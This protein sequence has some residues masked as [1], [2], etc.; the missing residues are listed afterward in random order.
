MVIDPETLFS[1]YL[2]DSPYSL[3]GELDDTPPLSRKELMLRKVKCLPQSQGA[4]NWEGLD[5]NLGLQPLSL[6]L[7]FAMMNNF[8]F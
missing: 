8:P 1:C 4:G 2:G 5:L 6:L 3:M 7:A